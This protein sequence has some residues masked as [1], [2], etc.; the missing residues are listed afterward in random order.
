M[1]IGAAPPIES[2]PQ[3]G[4]IRWTM[5]ADGPHAYPTD[6]D[7]WNNHCVGRLDYAVTTLGS[8]QHY[9]IYD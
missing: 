1:T 3:Q 9:A 5:V 7:C 6:L 4:Y 8:I 2:L